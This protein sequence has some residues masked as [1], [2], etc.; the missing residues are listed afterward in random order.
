MFSRRSYAGLF[1]KLSLHTLPAVGKSSDSTVQ[2]HH[3]RHLTLVLR[4]LES[5]GSLRACRFRA[6]L[7]NA[8]SQHLRFSISVETVIAGH[9]A[10]ILNA[11]STRTTAA[12]PPSV[13]QMS[14]IALPLPQ[15]L[16]D[17]DI[18][19][20]ISVL[21][22]GKLSPA[23]ADNPLQSKRTVRLTSLRFSNAHFC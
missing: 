6:F 9:D 19:T 18:C 1:S 3:W 8:S 12:C 10:D 23:S 14:D 21:R 16:S 11:R 5:R 20:T 15:H 4:P 13:F 7:R 17:D 2:Y 22:L